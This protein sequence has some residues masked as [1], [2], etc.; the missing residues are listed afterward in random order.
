MRPFLFLLLLCSPVLAQLKTDIEFAKP[1]GVSLTLDA[2]VP[3]G[4]LGSD[5]RDQLIAWLKLQLKP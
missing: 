4:K 2:F 1:G 5:Y 3:E